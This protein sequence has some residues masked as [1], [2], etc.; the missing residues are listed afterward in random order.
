MKPTNGFV[1]VDKRAK[2]FN[3]EVLFLKQGKNI[4]FIIKNINSLNI[5][6][7]CLL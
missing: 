5:N 2:A 3:N 6:A 4:E 7:S 1:G